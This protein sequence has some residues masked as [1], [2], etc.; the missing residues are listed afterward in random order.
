MPGL[1]GDLEDVVKADHNP[2][3]P[4]RVGSST[5]LEALSRSATIPGPLSLLTATS[6]ELSG[7]AMSGSG[8]ISV[9]LIGGVGDDLGMWVRGRPRAMGAGVV[10]LKV[11]KAQDRALSCQLLR[12]LAGRLAQ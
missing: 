3:V 1:D 12:W 2:G 6:R 9:A 11:A 8:A 4:S 10:E 5:G 7:S